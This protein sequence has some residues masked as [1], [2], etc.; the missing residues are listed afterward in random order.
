MSG[1]TP[2]P[3]LTPEKVVELGADVETL[4]RWAIPGKYWFVMPPKPGKID[5]HR[6]YMN[7]AKSFD[8]D[9]HEDVIHQ[10]AEYVR[11]LNVQFG[12]S[13]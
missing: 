13:L 9:S 11:E 3:M 4:N 2:K 8:G 1:H 7:N 6:L 5:P 10:A 12:E